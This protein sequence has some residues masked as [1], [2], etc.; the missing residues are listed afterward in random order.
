MESSSFYVA[1][2]PVTDPGAMAWWLA[3]L[4]ADLDGLRRVA[5]D[6]VIHYRAEDPVAH[7]IPAERMREIDTRYAA[8]MLRRLHELA[9]QPLTIARQ[10][11]QRLVGCCRDF[12]ILFLTLARHQG[13][14][15]RARVGFATYFVPGFNVDHEI[16]E[17]WSETERRWRL[18][19]PE[20][21]DDHLDP[22]NGA[23]LD[24]LDIPR[25]RFLTGGVAWLACRDGRADPARFVVDPGLD[26]PSTRSWPQLRNNLIHDLAVFNKVEPLLWDAWGFIERDDLSAAE[27]RLLDDVAG[28]TAAGDTGVAHAHAL[29]AGHPEPRMPPVVVSYDP[30]GGPPRQVRHAI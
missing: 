24:G 3:D 21:S 4:P 13:I 23:A 19:D 1:Q 16:A 30:L 14:A 5:R 25:D 6:L 26:L 15:A 20:L 27:E 17:V 22:T 2:S 10:P 28:V 29:Y 11:A 9:A 7:G 8:A 18:I 12:T